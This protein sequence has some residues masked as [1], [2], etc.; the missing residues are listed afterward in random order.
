MTDWSKLE[1]AHGKATDLPKL[2][3]ELDGAD[4]SR[5]AAMIAER[6][7]IGPVS[8]LPALVE[9]LLT[10]LDAA[11]RK[12][13]AALWRLLAEVV[14]VDPQSFA[15][16][17][18][19]LAK[20]AKKP[21]RAAVELVEASDALVRDV[22]AKDGAVAAAAAYVAALLPAP[23]EALVLA[24]AARARK[25]AAGA[26]RESA[27]LAMATLVRRELV[28]EVLPSL[29]GELRARA[30][31]AIARRIATKKVS[32]EDAETLAAWLATSTADPEQAWGDGD[33]GNLASAALRGAG[34]GAA[35][36]PSLVQAVLR[37]SDRD[38]LRNVEL[39]VATLFPEA[40]PLTAS[41][42]DEAQR[43]ALRALLDGGVDVALPAQ[44][45]PN[46]DSVRALV[47]AAERGAKAPPASGKTSGATPA[48]RARPPI[49]EEVTLP[50][51][52]RM[53]WQWFEAEFKKEVTSDQLVAA[54]E[55]RFTPEQRW[56]LVAEGVIASRGHATPKMSFVEKMMPLVAVDVAS[57]DE[58][59]ASALAA[60][61]DCRPPR[62][63]F[64]ALA[65]LRLPPKE[66]EARADALSRLVAVA[67]GGNDAAAIARLRAAVPA[68]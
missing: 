56:A 38:R 21:L 14:F 50:K 42:I 32:K 60:G 62:A 67:S 23:S 63:L 5:A 40:R 41:S 58:A 59:V 43:T 55:E 20:A 6:F 39:L 37:S 49:E 53:A 33:L 9:E 22:G 27:V 44:G 68:R 17:P 65:I 13:R 66:I 26:A 1:H 29:G 61:R 10:R 35:L 51:G 19:K 2:L 8:A 30:V 7:A 57:V 36:A 52:T 3:S 18:F 31:E 28:D 11:R 24:V 15:L 34:D 46:V 64:G 25:K 45:L 54:F 12:D 48:A 47:E 16:D 4:G